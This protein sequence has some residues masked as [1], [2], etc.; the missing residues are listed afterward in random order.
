MFIINNAH[1][2]CQTDGTDQKIAYWEGTN[3]GL[4]QELE[5]LKS[6][7]INGLDIDHV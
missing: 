5:A 3:G 2:L 1:I 6:E 4:I 7:T